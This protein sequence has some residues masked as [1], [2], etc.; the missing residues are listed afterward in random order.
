MVS[1]N[2]RLGLFGFMPHPAMDAATNVDLGLEDQRDAM[3][4]VQKNIEAFGGDPQ[5]VTLAGESA[6]AGAICQ[7][8]A[9]RENVAGQ[10][11]WPAYDGTR[12][13]PASD[14]VMFFTPG[15]NHAYKAYGPRDAEAH[16]AHQCAFWNTIV[17][18]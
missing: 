4:W 5:N 18:E 17:P 13:N 8:L 1:V 2:Y 14:T 11:V 7:H 12:A 16:V 9:S 3:R 6:G 15:D 10:P